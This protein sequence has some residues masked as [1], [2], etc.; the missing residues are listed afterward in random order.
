MGRGRGGGIGTPQLLMMPKHSLCA[1]K[2]HLLHLY[3][4]R[5]NM[6]F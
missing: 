2:L 3:P 4:W 5:K 6:L 1:D